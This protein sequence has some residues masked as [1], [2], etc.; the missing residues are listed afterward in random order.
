MAVI[1]VNKLYS[2]LKKKIGVRGVMSGN[3]GNGNEWVMSVRGNEC[4]VPFSGERC[5]VIFMSGLFEIYHKNL[6]LQEN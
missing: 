4:Q 6:C 2:V 3:G 5:G 1:L